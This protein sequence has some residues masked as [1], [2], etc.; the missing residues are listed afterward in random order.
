[1]VAQP[2]PRPGKKGSQGVG[3]ILQ[4]QIMNLTPY[5]LKHIICAIYAG[6]CVHCNTQQDMAGW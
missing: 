1:M 4:M 2:S 6:N 5:Y 3:L